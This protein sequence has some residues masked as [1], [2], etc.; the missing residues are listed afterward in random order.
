MEAAGVPSRG[1]K[2]KVKRETKFTRRIRS[3]VCSKS[4]RVS[5]GKPTITSLVKAMPGDRLAGVVDQPQILLPGIAPVHPPQHPVA[6]R[7]KR[8]VEMPGYLFTRGDGVEQL[9]RGILGMRGHEA[10]EKIPFDG[11]D[12]PQKRGEIRPVRLPLP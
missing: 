8:Q 2:I 10:D 7:L 12:P 6:A 3:S 5:P 1:E 4:S 11:V 9:R